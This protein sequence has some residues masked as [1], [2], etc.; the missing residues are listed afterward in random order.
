MNSSPCIERDSVRPGLPPTARESITRT[1]THILQQS[2]SHETPRPWPARQRHAI[3]SNRRVA[4]HTRGSL[5]FLQVSAHNCPPYQQYSPQPS[6]FTMPHRVACSE[7][8]LTAA[9]M[10]VAGDEKRTNPGS[11]LRPL[12]QAENNGRN[13]R[14]RK[15][16]PRNNGPNFTRPSQPTGR[17]HKNNATSQR[18]RARS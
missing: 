3:R 18:R 15:R 5:Q 14:N 11:E 16:E 2:S 17:R 6:P 4:L 7:R 9:A 12:R 1:S 13:K 10:A 8:P